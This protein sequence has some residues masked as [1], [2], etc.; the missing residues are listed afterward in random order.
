MFRQAIKRYSTLQKNISIKF[1]TTNKK[2]NKVSLSYYINHYVIGLLDKR[3]PSTVLKTITTDLQQSVVE[4]LNCT[5]QDNIISAEDN[6]V[7]LDNSIVVDSF[8]GDSSF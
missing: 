7:S 2:Q 6:I 4:N 8:L 3:L 5:I 1:I